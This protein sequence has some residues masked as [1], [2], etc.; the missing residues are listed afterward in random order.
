MKTN[1]KSIFCVLLTFLFLSPGVVKADDESIRYVHEIT[2]SRTIIRHISDGLDIV[3]Y[4]EYDPYF[5]V[6]R[7]GDT[8]SNTFLLSRMDSIYDFEI[9]NGKVYFCG[10]NYAG[11]ATVGFF[12]LTSLI[13]PS[14][15]I[16]V[17]F[18]ELSNMKN[19]KAIE[20]GAFASRN[21]V[22]GIG[23]SVDSKGMMVDMTDET[24][25]WKI[26]FSIV[27]GDTMILSDLAIINNYVVV[28]ATKTG[29]LYFVPAGYLW[30][31]SKPTTPGNS[32]FPCTATLDKHPGIE[33]TKYLITQ[34]RIDG[35]VTAY[36]GTSLFG[37]RPI[38]L[39]YYNGPSYVRSVLFKEPTKNTFYLQDIEREYTTNTV[40]VVMGGKYTNST[41]T[42]VRSKIYEIPDVASLPSTI[43]AHFYDGIF[44]TSI[45]RI[46]SITIGYGHFVFSGYDKPSGYGTPYYAKLLFGGFP[47]YCKSKVENTLRGITVQNN[48]TAHDLFRMYIER[49]PVVE[50]FSIKPLWVE[51]E[52]HYPSRTSENEPEQ[53]TEKK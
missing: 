29:P 31:I 53:E 40:E 51:T 30:Y 10:E 36:H 24:T 18:F 9:Y 50:T 7:E 43:Y 20:V 32:L 8:A 19:V 41:G 21:H 28:T 35:F 5:M 33:G 42:F 3:C 25:Y 6:F 17:S 15:S 38:I 49:T 52:C 14:S 4:H 34:L 23:E 11:I 37:T 22:V 26:N 48:R 12:D 27:G 13:Y 46:G 47:G 2:T 16:N 45:D 39:S 44:L 1:T